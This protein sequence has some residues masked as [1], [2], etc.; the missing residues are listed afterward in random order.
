MK[1]LVDQH[2]YVYMNVNRLDTKIEGTESRGLSKLSTLSDV[3]N[4][5][6]CSILLCA[7]TIF[8]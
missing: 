2:V 6:I 5:F 1:W 7:E 3:L 4:V 8:Y